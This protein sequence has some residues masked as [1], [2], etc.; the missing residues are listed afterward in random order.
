MWVHDLSLELT[1]DSIIPLLSKED[2]DNFDLERVENIYGIC[3]DY[4]QY[5]EEQLYDK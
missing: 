5:L 4:P 2:I 3:T 1:E